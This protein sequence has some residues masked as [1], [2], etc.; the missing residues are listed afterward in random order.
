MADNL[1]RA[2]NETNQEY[3]KK[4]DIYRVKL[5]QGLAERIENVFTELDSLVGKE[6]IDCYIKIVKEVLPQQKAIEL[7]GE[8]DSPMIIIDR[9]GK[10]INKD[11][12]DKENG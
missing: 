7:R 4:R 5:F 1:D 3:L 8:G 12:E 2:E 10:T 11:S 6:Y 9:A